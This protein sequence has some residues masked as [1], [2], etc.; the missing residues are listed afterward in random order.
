M[1][2]VYVN[3]Q[4]DGDVVAVMGNVELGPEARVR[5]NVVVVGGALTR[6]PA[7]TIG[8]GVERVLNTDWADFEWLRPWIDKCLLYGRPLAFANGL[9][10]AWTLAL[11]M[12]ALYVVIAVLFRSGVERCVETLESKP[13]KCLASFIN[14]AT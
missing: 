13:G 3:G 5:G 7:A 11:G 4:V 10:W 9:G 12:L 8:G 6:D 1:G 14:S 2:S